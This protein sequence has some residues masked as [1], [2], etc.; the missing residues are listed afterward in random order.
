MHERKWWWLNGLGHVEYLSLFPLSGLLSIPCIVTLSIPIDV[1]I[2]L[3]IF[4]ISE[5]EIMVQYR[6]SLT[7]WPIVADCRFTEE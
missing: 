4:E 3:S 7:H 5:M 2:K 6:T 1:P